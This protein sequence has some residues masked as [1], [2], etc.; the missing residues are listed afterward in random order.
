ML[1]P[2]G[3][4][5]NNDSGVIQ[6]VGYDPDNSTDLAGNPLP[7]MYAWTVL[8]PGGLPLNSTL[9]PVLYTNAAIQRGL[10]N[11]SAGS[12]QVRLPHFLLL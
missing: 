7:F 5:R 4:A 12:L 10:L 11:F 6:A 3:S 8:S 2:G 9:S 1:L